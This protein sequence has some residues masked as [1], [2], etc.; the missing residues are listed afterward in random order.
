[1]CAYRSMSVARH[2]PIGSASQRA[3][4]PRSSSGTA[5]PSLRVVE[6]IAEAL[7]LD[8]QL[9]IKPPIF[10]AGGRVKGAVH[11]RC[12]AYT[13]RRLQ[14]HGWT[15]AREVEIIH[16]RSHGWI[17][18]LAFDRRTG[19]LLIIEIKTRL[20]DLGALERQLGWYERM[21]WQAARDLGWRPTR[22]VSIVLALASDE[23][24]RV[25]RSHRDLLALAFPSRATELGEVIAD[26]G[27]R[28]FGRGL[29][30]IDPSSRRRDWLIKTSI[31]GR[32][33][34]L[35]YAGY[36]D[37][38][39]PAAASIARAPAETNAPSEPR[40]MNVKPSSSSGGQAG[41]VVDQDPSG[42]AVRLGTPRPRTE[43]HRGRSA[44]RTGPGPPG[45]AT[46]RPG[47]RTGRRPR[48]AR[49]ISS[50]APS[51]PVDSIWTMPTIRSFTTRAT[52]AWP[53][54]PSR[55]PRVRSATPRWPTGG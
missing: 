45:R 12:S 41:R 9:L 24:E 39:R 28:L 32:R 20:D 46:D 16:G 49:A 37:A 15:T 18:L 2:S 53:I 26:P 21:A 8:I 17:D 34:R 4:S 7:G 11:D 50:T 43:A 44:R 10:V 14:G 47:P 13:D 25:V 42:L 29:A 55:A 38:A 40:P 54:V 35:P 19:T 51:P 6:S 30:L 48:R 22:V 31:D 5:N 1:M 52:S 33:S 36:A 23:I 27:K 3:T